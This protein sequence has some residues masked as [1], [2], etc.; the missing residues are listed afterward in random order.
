MDSIFYLMIFA[1]ALLAVADLVVGVSNDAVNFLNSAI[2]SKAISFKK[3]MIIASLGVFIGAVFS[4]GMMEVARK[5]IFMP[6]K[7]YFDEIMFIFMAV[8]IGDILLLDFFNTLGM[9]TSTTVSIVFNL[10]GAAV[11]MALI[12][13]GMSDTETAADLVNYINTEKAKQIISG[14]LLSVVISFTVGML[15][16]WIS[17]LVFSFQYEKKV[18]NF[19]FV[20]AGICLTAI[21]YFIFF[22][23]LKGTPFY[24]DIKDF[25]AQNSFL[26]IGLML[27]FWTL[28]MFI[29]DKVFKINVLI[30]VIGV[31]TFGL[32]LAFAG[33]DLVNFIGVPMAAYHSY[34]A[35]SVSGIPASEFSMEILSE[36]VP[37]E[38]GLLFIAGAIM[39]VTLAFSKKART[40]ADTSIDLS[41]QGDGSERFQPNILSR[42]IVKGSTKLVSVVSTIL[43]A[44][45]Q[46]K[47]TNSFQTPAIEISE[48]KAKALPA[49]DMIRASINL[50]VAGILISIA[51][52]MKLPL[53]TTY[54][55]FMVAMGTSL[56]D[57]AWGRESAV[58]RVAGVVNVI[59]GWFFTAFS[60][61][62]F[63]GI[64][65]YIIYMGRGAAVA[66]LLL[67]AGVL[68]VRNYLSH[69]KKANA[70]SDH[71]SL[72]KSASQTVQGIIEESADNVAK[73][74]Y[75]TTS[76]F[77][78]VVDGLSN[79]DTGALKK[80]R[81]RVGKFEDE[82][83]S[84][85]NHLFY[86]IKNLDETSVRGSNF[87]IMVLANLTDVVQ[88]LEF[89]AKKSFK[90]IDN[91]HKPLS[92]SQISDL[93]EIQTTFDG[94]LVSVEQAFTSKSFGDLST[95]LDQEDAILALISDKI[96]AQIARTRKE[97]VSPKNTTLYFNLLLETKD[98]VKA[99]MRLV[100][101]Y[102]N[103]SSNS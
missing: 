30:I 34:E 69:K 55:T 72:K 32:A 89:I 37:T 27:A 101:E 9:P 3:I 31:G 15:V 56:A 41:R 43:P 13:I 26:V 36:K 82:V 90:H 35:W 102:H 20:F 73:S 50:A 99:V 67:F 4:S 66:I 17:R 91:N 95:C 94:M 18:K 58:Y 12:K 88:S 24:G 77:N 40:V 103:S 14:I 6:S 39:V 2:G 22:K 10:L 75:R 29:I 19:G 54:V 71:S 65:T 68:V 52:S 81:K 98:L 78:G 47:I 48:E 83:E 45:V 97:E 51:T 63:A 42:S 64:L 49:F 93:N 60:A 59:G 84:L 92:K 1:L 76:I 100:E 5:G 46:T 16:Q 62:T 70:Q 96:D 8:M 86:F 23:G 33:N 87:Y 7:F 80:M 21:G 57:R 38:P 25:L 61:F 79:Q 11:V 44:A 74:I 85:R 28:L 53:S